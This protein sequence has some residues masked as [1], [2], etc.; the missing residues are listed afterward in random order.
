MLLMIDNSHMVSPVFVS[1][2]F[3]ALVP[4]CFKAFVSPS[5]A[6]FL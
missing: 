6:R 4:C 2:R 3:F 1:F 5:S